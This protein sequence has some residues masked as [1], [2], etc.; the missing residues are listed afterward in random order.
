MHKLCVKE[1]TRRI[2]KKKKIKM[3]FK[4][5]FL[6]QKRFQTINLNKHQIPEKIKTDQHIFQITRFQWLKIISSKKKKYQV[7]P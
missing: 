6:K 5:T 4:I 3:V 2:R 1:K 7:N